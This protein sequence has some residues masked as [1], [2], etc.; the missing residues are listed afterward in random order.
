MATPEYMAPEILNYILYQNK[1]KHQPKLLE[2]LSNYQQPHVIDVWSLGC[3]VMEII[4]GIPLW[5]SLK[6]IVKDKEKEVLRQGLFASKGRVFEKIVEKQMHVVANLNTYI[7]DHNYSGVKVD[8]DIKFLVK[9]M[10]ALDPKQRISPKEICQFLH[11]TVFPDSELEEHMQQL[12]K[13]I[14]LDIILIVNT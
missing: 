13:V 12:S 8:E 7:D 4:N 2:Y 10:L 3:V 5:M 14:W 6:T 11:K 1:L 9:S